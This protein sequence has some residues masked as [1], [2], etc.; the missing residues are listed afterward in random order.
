[1][2]ILWRLLAVVSALTSVHDVANAHSKA[3]GPLDYLSLVENPIIETP[4][5][6]VHASSNFDITF[7]LHRKKQRIKLTLEPSH[8]VVAE[9]ASVNYLDS[10][11]KIVRTE[12]IDRNAHK[13]FKGDTW[14]QERDGSWTNIGWARISVR[15]DGDDPLF[16]GTFTVSH[17]SHHVLLRSHYMQTR[18]E[19]DPS[20]EPTDDEYMVI[21]RDSDISLPQHTELKRRGEDALTCGHDNL[22]FNM[23][24][25]HPIYK[26]LVDRSIG[27]WGSM[28]IRSLFGKRQIDTVP[29]G[30]NS[31]SV[32]LASSIGSTNGCP[33][34]RKVAL[35]GVATDCS[36]TASFN[37]SESAHANVITQIN[38]ASAVYEKTFNITL[39]LQSLN[40]ASAECPGSPPP[41]TPWN[42]GCGGNTTIT[43]RLNSF[44]GWRGQQNDSNA[45]WTLLTNC[46]TGAEVGLAWLGQLCVGNVVS[47]SG[48]TVSGANVVAKTLT[49]WQV[50]A[51]ESGHTFGAV[52]DCDSQTCSDGTS[53]NA[54]QCCPLSSSTCDAGAQFIMNPST[55]NDISLFSACTVGNICSAML[56]NSVNST[57]LSDN[58]AVTTI[59]GKQCG[60]GIVEAGEECD[61]GG[62]AGCVNNTCCNP[63]TCTFIN[64]AVCDPANDECCTS[65]QFAAQGTVCRASTGVCN[66]QEVCSGTNATCPADQIAPNG[67]TCGSSL[68]C[69]SGQ[70]TSRDQQ[71]KTLMGSYTTNNDTYACNSQDCT[72]S[73]ASPSFGPGECYSMQQNFLDG[74]TCGGGGSCSNGQ[75]VGSSTLQEV[76]SW[77]SDNK[78][79]VIG[80]ACGV[81]GLL[82]ILILG[83][84]IRRCR[85]GGRRAPRRRGKALSPPMQ[86]QQ[87]PQHTGGWG[88]PNNQWEPTPP[89]VPPHFSTYSYGARPSVR[90]A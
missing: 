25:N 3:R 90:Y 36:Y 69:A 46:P 21:F 22:R 37:S 87:W 50:I 5:H 33:N 53:E 64:N 56:R 4:S 85:G 16:E 1:M 15:K 59:S 74:T 44:S 41:A 26:T 81:G 57:C 39:G 30:G 58:K 51:H 52:H 67:Q 71:C 60:N 76:G 29:S 14:I 61:C 35:V 89:P 66:P 83:C 19:L 80:I 11:G 77:I 68:S 42:I 75:C 55:G 13:I 82:L 34:T 10:E 9:G 78:P 23:D 72:L 18:Q 17:D 62:V 63:T 24:R 28:S 45:Y 27:S 7:N 86:Q 6:R 12:S 40:V 38:S 70:C 84:C 88:G 8:G 43:D 20:L 49:E 73:C 65:C 54:Q 2:R 79:L 31:G 48:E 32:N 47:G